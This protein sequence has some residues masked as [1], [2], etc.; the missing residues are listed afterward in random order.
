LYNP[1]LKDFGPRLSLAY[2]PGYTSGFFGSLFGGPGKSSL[3]LGAGITYDNIGQ[4]IALDSDSN[5]SP[6][7]STALINN[8]QEFCLGSA[9]CPA[10]AV[11]APRFSGTCTATGCTGLPAA[12]PPFFTPPTTAAFPFT[13]APTVSLTG[14]AVDPHLRTPYAIHL[15]A[16]FQRQLPKNV[17]L[18]VTYVGTLGRR[19]LGKIDY[20]QYLDIRDPQS[21]V[22]LWSA[23]RQVVKIGGITPQGAGAAI[24][25][26]NFAQLGTIQSIP[27]FSNL[28]PNMPAFAAA[29][30][31]APAD[32]A[33][34]TGMKALTPT[35]AF[36]AYV[37]QDL[38][39]TGNSGNNASWGCA[40][41]PMDT[42][43]SPGGLP[44]PWS[45]KLDPQ[46]DGLVLFQQQFQT[47]PGWSNEASSNYHSLQISVR[48][49]VGIA[50]FGAN[51]VFSKSLDNSSS[52]GSAES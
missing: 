47:L 28:L 39:N 44:S 42:F 15:T 51:Y 49:T 43:V 31:C 40:L 33:C 11:P 45:T 9:G 34:N 16:S 12:G 14:F 37:M 52:G 5:G 7:T 13:P 19:L 18:D 8:S 32:T 30:L 35:Q 24:D 41:F 26:A 50:T 6:G 22:D 3:R 27:F 25:P 46:G 2:S 4:V 48:K 23:Y 38:G 29:F 20:A 1:Y 36:Y 17:V 21:K 10:P